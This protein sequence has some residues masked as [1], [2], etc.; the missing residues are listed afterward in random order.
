MIRL[1]VFILPVLI[2]L[3]SFAQGVIKAETGAR[4]VSETGS[5]WVVDNGAFTLTSPTTATPVTMAN[6]KIEADASL[7]IGP[8][9]YLSVTGTLTNNAGNTGLVV[10]SDATGA[11]SLI[12][13]TASVPATVNRY[14]TGLSQAWHLLSSPVAAQSI[15]GTFTPDPATSYDFFAW[16]EPTAEWVNF[17]NTTVPITWNTANGSTN[18]T[19]GKGYLVE[20]TGT[21]LTKQ[22]TGNLNVGA[23]SPALTK[24]GAATYT[25]FNLVGNPYSSAIDWKSAGGWNRTNLVASGGGYVMSIWNDALSTGNY[26]VFN[27]AG[28]S[29]S[30]TNGVTQYI[31][32]GQGFMVKAASAGTIGMADGIRVHNAQAWLK[33]TEAIANVLRVKV[34]GNANTYSDEIIIEFGHQNADGGAEKMFSFYET[35][36]SLYT[37]KP[38]GN[39]SIDFR[40]EPEAITI[41]MSF[42]AGA[43][44]N[45]TLTASQMESFT[46]S[47]AIT[48]ED[49]KLNATQNLMQ[50]P[51]YTFSSAK[52]DDGARFLVH[53]GGAFSISENAKEQPVT[54]Y[55]SGRTIYIANKSG[56]VMKGGVTVYNMIGQP[57]MQRPLSENPLTMISL[58]GATGYYLVKVLTGDQVYSG[59]VFIK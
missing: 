28:S 35:A 50:N 14:I 24:T 44:G 30:G 18:F 51:V 4:I 13:G 23:I 10:N 43:D 5:Y 29:G 48:L 15:S 19:A 33:S 39:Y 6:L 11:G 12:N 54:V 42:K 36:P 2:Q 45:Y 47:T 37:V 25:A 8:L 31:P 40:G 26:G 17:K 56:S 32:V 3:S 16:Y 52:T 27:S 41:P 9:N 20:Y 59:K 34:T 1:L 53:F 55:A 38:D 7:T 58:S 49:V 46:S 21:G 22:F 57:V